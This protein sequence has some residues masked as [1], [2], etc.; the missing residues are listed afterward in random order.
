M[1]GLLFIAQSASLVLPILSGGLVLMW[2]LRNNHLS[3][4]GVPIDSYQTFG[5]K[6]LFGDNKTWRGVIVY[7]VISI[8]VC[9]ILAF[10]QTHTSA[11]HPVFS[12]N[13]FL[14]GLVFSISYMLGEFLNSFVKRRLGIA[15]GEQSGKKIQRAIDNVDGMITLSLVLVVVLSVALESVVIAVGIGVILHTLTDNILRQQGL[16]V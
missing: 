14:L 6:R 13:P 7:L 3:G 15:A 2:I 10:I 16:K 1:A 5:G 8:L 11:V 9:L 12:F 4:L